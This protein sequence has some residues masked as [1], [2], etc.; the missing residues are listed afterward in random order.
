M[1]FLKLVNKGISIIR[2]MASVLYKRH[3]RMPDNFMSSSQYW[4]VRYASGGNS[5]KGSYGRLAEFKAGIL[6]DF[7]QKN[8]IHGVIEYGF[9][10]GN[11]LRLASYPEYLGFDISPDAVAQCR[12][13]FRNDTSKSFLLV[14]EY[15]GQTAEL[16]LS[17]DVIYHLVEDHIFEEYM[18]RLFGSS[19][20]FVI[21]YSTNT[22]KNYPNRAPHVRHREFST[23]IEANESAWLLAEKIESPFATESNFETG[24]FRPDFYVYEKKR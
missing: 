10:D 11:Q 24:D 20:R 1:T 4:I 17:L 14:S 8:N 13:R 23:W 12:K 19:L 18:A 6:N 22:N 21:I 7:V 5:G 9:G 2:A 15:D 16:G 3:R